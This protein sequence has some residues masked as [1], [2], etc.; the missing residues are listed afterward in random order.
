[1]QVS[2]SRIALGSG[3]RD[4]LQSATREI[5]ERLHSHFAF[6]RLTAGS[7]TAPE[8]R[9]LLA[10]L[11]GF[12]HPLEIAILRRLETTAQ[13]HIDLEFDHRKR[14]H[15]LASDLTFL[16]LTELELANLPLCPVP[17]SHDRIG[18]VLGCLYVKEGATLGGRVLARR[19]DNLFPPGDL[20]GRRFFSG[21]P[22]DGALWRRFCAVIELPI[23]HVDI[24]DMVSAASETFAMFEDWMSG[25]EINFV[26]LRSK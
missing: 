12:H 26:P 7:I 18:R 6:Q 8:Y 2:S 11:Y 13:A 19:V 5:H 16:G 20:G 14:A 22:D 4:A 24:D 25:T 1:M 3:A 23:F 15:L 21:L 9:A 17:E 10:R